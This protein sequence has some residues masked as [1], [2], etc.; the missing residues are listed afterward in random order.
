MAATTENINNAFFDGIY[1][2][3]WRQLIPN[4][5]SEAEVDFIVEVARLQENDSVLDVMCGYGRHALELGNRGIQVT[6]V[7]NLP[8]Y[9]DEIKEKAI[10]ASV[11]VTPVLSGALDMTLTRVY[12]A[13]ICMGNSFA[14]FNKQD[15][16]SLLKNISAHLKPGGVLVINSWMIAEIAIKHFREKDWHQVNDYKYLLDYK[17]QFSPNRIE[18]EQTI[19]TPDGGVEVLHGIDYIFTL[20]ELE[21]MFAEAGMSTQALYSTPRKR[22]FVFGDSRV[23]IVVEKLS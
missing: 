11:S 16:G 4:G 23:Y 14:F 12:D 17:F 5:L 19:V 15:C 1:K 13:A 21:T 7:D 6:A 3:V 20:D 2:D 18:S 10:A 22:P 8:A 9:V